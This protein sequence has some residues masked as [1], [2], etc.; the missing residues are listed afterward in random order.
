M[1]VDEIINPSLAYLEHRQFVWTEKGGKRECFSFD[2]MP[3]L[4]RQT[5]KSSAQSETV[6]SERAMS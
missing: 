4:L 2:Q 5:M 3:L 6:P 1:K